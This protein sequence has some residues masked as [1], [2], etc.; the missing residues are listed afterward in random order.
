MT[1]G[2]RNTGFKKILGA[3]SA[4]GSPLPEF[5]TDEAHDYF[6]T[7]I[8]IHE[9]F[10][11]DGGSDGGSTTPKQAANEIQGQIVDMIRLDSQISKKEIAE[12]L[13]MSIDGVKYHM[14]RMTELGMIRYIGTSRKGHW[15]ILK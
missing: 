15:E 13:G 1:S 7:R 9:D 11:D 6:V 10:Y 2:R 5:E 14:K 3:L 12:K 8:F 4:N